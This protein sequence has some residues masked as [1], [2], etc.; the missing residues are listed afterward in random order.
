MIFGKPL[1]L[2]TCILVG[3]TNLAAEDNSPL[4]WMDNSATLLVGTGFEVPGDDITTLTLEHVSGWTWGDLFAFVD[5]QD[6]HDS[7]TQDTSWYGEFSPRLSLGNLAG[8]KFSDDG[9]VRDILISTTWERGKNGVEA[10]LIGGAVDLNLPGFSFFKV[11]AYARKD[12]GLGAGFEDMQ[13]TFAWS[14]PIKVGNEAFVVDGFIDY[15]VG[16]GP[17]ASTIHFVPQ[18]KW[19]IGAKWGRP[20]KVWLGT[21]IDIWKNQ[22][23]IKDTPDFNTDQVAINAILK[24]H[25]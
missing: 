12:T 18:L 24:V 3:T 21:E 14:K 16:W 5:L 22:F 6:Y 13:W 19:D 25:F 4:L 8:L 10:L 2:T 23:G 17:Q 7:A 20:G 15:V 11:N 9:L 1:T